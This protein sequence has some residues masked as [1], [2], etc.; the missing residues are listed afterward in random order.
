LAS[1]VEKLYQHDYIPQFYPKS[2]INKN[3]WLKNHPMSDG[4]KNHERN[5]A[6]ND[7]NKNHE[8]HEKT[9]PKED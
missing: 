2:N 4:N 6:M 3:K 1:W 9:L 7:G 8:R 5:H